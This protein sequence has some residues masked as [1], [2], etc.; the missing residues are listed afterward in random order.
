[1]ISRV[2]A[3]IRGK[4]QGVFFR[5]STVEKAASLNIKGYV[6]NRNDN[7]VELDAEG[8]KEQ[9]EQLLQWCHEGPPAAS[10]ESVETTWLDSFYHYTNF[11]IH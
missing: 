5:A 4:V 11:T 9:L 2:K 6:K 10:V 1:M 8:N 7:S 3:V